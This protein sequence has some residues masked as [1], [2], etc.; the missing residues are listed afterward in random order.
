MDYGYMPNLRR[1][2]RSLFFA[3]ISDSDNYILCLL[4]IVVC[5]INV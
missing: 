5:E 2:R 3:L 4:F 1:L